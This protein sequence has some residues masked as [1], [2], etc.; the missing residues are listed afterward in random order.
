MNSIT[1]RILGTFTM[2]IQQNYREY[3]GMAN[4]TTKKQRTECLKMLDKKK[5]FRKDKIN[6]E[7]I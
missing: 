4:R 6:L 7:N 3:N 5:T 1:N 2:I